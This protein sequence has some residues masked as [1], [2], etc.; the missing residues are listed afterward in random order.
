MMPPP[1]PKKTPAP[2][3]WSRI[4]TILLDMDGTLLDLHFDDTFFRETVPHAVARQR[5]L[6]LEEAKRWVHAT[7]QRVAGTLAWYDLDHWSRT[8]GMDIP[9]L[10]E[11]VAHLI[12]VHPQTMGFLQALREMNK[13]AH[14]VTNAHALSLALKLRRTPIGPHMA[15]LTSSHE[16]GHPKESSEFW[17]LL[18]KKMGFDK[19]STLLV[20][21]SEPV[22]L[23]AKAFGIGH[24]RHISAPSSTQPPNPSQHF[25]AVLDLCAL[26]PEAPDPSAGVRPV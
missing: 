6:G 16:L 10:K 24:L 20:D 17:P 22:L 25:E 26:L 8:L 11:E 4:Q 14:L 5:G 3:P 13:S 18:Q 9:L 12:Q 7:Y 2:L 23:A 21:D 15:S 1:T 19:A